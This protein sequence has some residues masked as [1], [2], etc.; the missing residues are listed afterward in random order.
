MIPRKEDLAFFDPFLAQNRQNKCKDENKPEQFI[1]QQKWGLFF[2]F[3]G[4]KQDFVEVFVKVLL[5]F[6]GR[7]Y[8]K[9]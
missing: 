1:H 5:T 9:L 8:Q 2:I 3:N 4:C 7:V 6:T